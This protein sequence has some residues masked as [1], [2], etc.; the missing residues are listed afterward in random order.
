M[1][2]GNQKQKTDRETGAPQWVVEVFAMDESDGEVIRVT[3][4][5][6]QPKVSQGQPV[7]VRNL[8]AIP[9]TNNGTLRRG[10]PGHH[11]RAQCPAQGC[12][13][14]HLAAYGCL[15]V[16]ANAPRRGTCPHPSRTEGITVIMTTTST[17][18]N[19]E[20]D[21]RTAKQPRNAALMSCESRKPEG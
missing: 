5:G 15:I 18:S 8:E 11:D 20:H 3:V 6:H 1:E 17:A 16:P 13:S 10:V 14:P 7:L 19:G 4:A 2:L 12:L 21:K 9:W